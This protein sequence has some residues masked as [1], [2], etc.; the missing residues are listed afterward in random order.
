MKYFL[1][2]SSSSFFFLPDY[3]AEDKHLYSHRLPYKV[4]RNVTLLRQAAKQ[5]CVQ[6]RKKFTNSLFFNFL[7][8]DEKKLLFFLIGGDV[9]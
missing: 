4:G 1:W 3:L 5:F 6:I 8:F 2:S 9:I 7:T